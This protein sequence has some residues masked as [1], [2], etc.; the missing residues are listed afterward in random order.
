M[1]IDES[2]PSPGAYLDAA[3]TEQE[4][5]AKYPN[6]PHNHSNTLPFHDLYLTLFNPLND[7]K[8]KP[9]GPIG[10]R[11]RL[12]P[13][14]T[15]SSNPQEV[16]RAIIEKFISRWRQDV[17][18]DIYPAFRLIIPEKDRDR[19]TYG[20]KEKAIGKLLV[21]V[22]KIDKN[23]EDGFNLLKWKL[24]GQ[25]LSSRMAGDYAGR[26]FEVISKRAM[27]QDPGNLTIGEVNDLLD[28]LSAAPR[29]ENQRPLGGVLQEHERR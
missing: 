20:L 24:P 7:T 3:Q 18:D 16:K 8:K 1:D 10:N 27:L 4:L 9:T 15:N 13:H 25:S 26:C 28:K 21:K 6:R 5:D 17:W 23:S 19:A 22:M 29:E 11:R 2:Q 14:S 12:G